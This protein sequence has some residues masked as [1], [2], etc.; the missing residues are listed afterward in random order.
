[1]D[2]YHVIRRPLITEKGT[3]QSKASHEASKTRP[4]RGGS[5]SFEVHPEASKIEIRD[6]IEKIYK[7]HVEAVRTCTRRGK[8]RRYRGL[9]G[10]MRHWKKAVV[11]LKPEFHIDLF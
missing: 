5:Y 1:M 8:S 11:V 7:V 4:G 10:L 3:H 9:P 6:A 2:I